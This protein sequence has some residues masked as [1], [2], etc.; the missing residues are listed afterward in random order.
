[1]DKCRKHLSMMLSHFDFPRAS[2]STTE[3][4]TRSLL[5]R[6]WSDRSFENSR[7]VH[8]E[9]SHL[10]SPQVPSGSG[11]MYAAEISEH[12]DRLE[13]YSYMIRSIQLGC[14]YIITKQYISLKFYFL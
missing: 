11:V 7:E 2:D 4:T 6:G 3:T 10:S 12:T 1:M 5:W 13:R 8:G 9:M 14:F